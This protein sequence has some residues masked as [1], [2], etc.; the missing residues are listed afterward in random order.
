[1][2]VKGRIEYYYIVLGGLSLLVIEVKYILGN[3]QERLNAIAQV[4]AECDG[5]QP[6]VILSVRLHVSLTACDYANDRRHFPPATVY[7]VLCD[8]TTFEFYSFDG[9]T[10]IFSRGIFPI[11]KPPAQALAVANYY[12]ESAGFHIQST[13]YLRDY[14]L[15]SPIGLQDWNSNIYDTL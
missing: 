8:G 15:R 9:K 11:P 5:T 13:T 4:I 7:S 14:V 10:K 6:S 3:A 2:S 12:A 1:M